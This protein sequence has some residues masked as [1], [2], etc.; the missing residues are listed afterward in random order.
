MTL[1]QLFH[2]IEVLEWKGFEEVE[3]KGVTFDS[4]EVGPG[5]LFV[6]IRGLQNDGRRYVDEAFQKGA[7]GVVVEKGGGGADPSFS[8]N[9]NQIVVSSTRKTLALLASRFFS[10]PSKRLRLIGITGTNGKTTTSFLVRSITE[11]EGISTGLIGSIHC[12]IGEATLPMSHTTP[13]PVELHRLFSKMVQKKMKAVVMEVSSHALTLDRVWGCEFEVAIFTNFTQ[14]HL[15]FHGNLEEYFQS[16]MRLFKD[17][18]GSTGS[19]QPEGK[20]LLNV[21]D[22]CYER[23]HAETSRRVLTYA[24]DRPAD[25]KSEQVQMDWK[26]VSFTARTPEGDFPITSQLVGRHNI[27]NILAAVGTGLLMGCSISSIQKGI[28]EVTHVPGRF[29]KVDEGQEFGVIVDY[30]HTEDALFR[31]LSTAANLKKGRLIT[32]FGCGGDRDRSKRPSMGRVAAEWSDVVFLTS[33]NPRTEDPSTILTDIEKGLF[34]VQENQSRM[35]AFWT[36]SDRRE[37]IEKALAMAGPKD[38]VVVAGKGHEDYQII[39]NQRRHFDDR[40]VCREM[41]R[42]RMIKAKVAGS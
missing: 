41:I 30:A 25:I 28:Q 27:Y 8:P 32:V 17:R 21:D 19:P 42:K 4:R 22:P 16:K 29:E 11:A 36:L 6:A 34:Q 26:G 2:G 33:D 7:I 24:I 14:D 23:I 13:E 5:F 15:D 35:Q 38:L 3:V 10:E 37:A 1:K 39:G 18:L 31:L 12:R 9:R 20:A 40:E